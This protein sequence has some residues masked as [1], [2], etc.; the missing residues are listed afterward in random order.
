MAVAE[1]EGMVQVC[2]YIF[3]PYIQCPVVF[4]FEFIIT[5][6]DGTVGKFCSYVDE[7]YGFL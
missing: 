1:D 4:P 2:V 6:M 5:A 7:R 3:L